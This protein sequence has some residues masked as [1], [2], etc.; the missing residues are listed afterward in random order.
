MEA[1][2]E[3]TEH[4]AALEPSRAARQGPELR[5]MWQY[6]LFLVLDLSVYV[7]VP[8]LQGT[9]SGPRAHLGRGCEP[10]GGANTSFPRSAFLKLD[11]DNHLSRGP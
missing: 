4:V 7:G 1:G 2:S 11:L 8:G 10:A 6:V 9:D 3:A 5:G